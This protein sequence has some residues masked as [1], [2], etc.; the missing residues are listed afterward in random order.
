MERMLIAVFD[1]KQQMET[2]CSALRERGIP[3]DRVKVRS[4]IVD[5]Q[6]KSEL[7]GNDD[8]ANDTGFFKRLFGSK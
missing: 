5:E 1:T 2:A 4:G 7:T 6:L 3:S 8:G